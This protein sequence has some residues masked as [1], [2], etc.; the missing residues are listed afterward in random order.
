MVYYN[1][2]ACTGFCHGGARGATES[3]DSPPSL[4]IKTSYLIKYTNLFRQTYKD[5]KT[6][7][8]FL[9]GLLYIYGVEVWTLGG[10]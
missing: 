5:L 9:N 3:V 8:S 1:T 6:I 7:K 2:E 4:T 10:M